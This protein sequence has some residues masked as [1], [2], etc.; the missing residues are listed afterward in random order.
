MIFGDFRQH[1]HISN[2]DNYTEEYSLETVHIIA[3]IICQFNNKTS[4]GIM[5]K[6]RFYQLA[7]TYI[8]NNGIKK[9]G[10]RGQ[11][12]AY[13]VMKQLYDRVVFKFVKVEPLTDPE[14]KRVM[15]SLIYLTEKRDGSV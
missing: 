13:E 6:K 5:S 15:E 14:S 4:K 12:V 11:K 3:Y 2:E 7:Q 9:F 1:L 8:L 10:T